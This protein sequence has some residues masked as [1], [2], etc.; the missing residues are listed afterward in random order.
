MSYKNNKGSP[1]ERPL[2][3]LRAAEL[4]E[5]INADHMA[6]LI[7]RNDSDL[8]RAFLEGTPEIVAMVIASVARLRGHIWSSNTFTVV[9][10]ETGQMGCAKRNLADEP[11]IKR[12]ITIA[13]SRAFTGLVLANRVDWLDMEEGRPKKS[14]MDDV[15]PMVRKDVPELVEKAMTL[16]ALHAILSDEA[17]RDRNDQAST[18][19]ANREMRNINAHDQERSGR[20]EY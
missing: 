10:L 18:G 6:K 9:F 11:D 12:S 4:H 1:E 8:G 2:H 17:K 19:L 13:A 16:D 20:F 7:E 14:I 5:M 15:I 3:Y